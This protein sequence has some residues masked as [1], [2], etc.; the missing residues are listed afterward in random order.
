MV[1]LAVAVPVVF[2]IHPI[3]IDDVF[4]HLA[5]G[6]WMFEHHQ[7]PQ[8]DP[9]SWSR[10]GAPWVNF[11]WLFQLVVYVLYQGGGINGLI[12]WFAALS[13]LIF[14]LMA[15]LGKTLGLTT[16]TTALLVLVAAVLA[17]G[18]LAYFRP[19][20]FTMLFGVMSLL[21]L[22]RACAGR[23]V[24]MLWLFPVLLWGWS[25]M[26]GGFG[27]GLL[28]LAI[29]AV[30]AL[31]QRRW[32]GSGAPGLV[33]NRSEWKQV[34]FVATA[35]FL[36]CV[37]N[38]YGLGLIENVIWQIQ[39]SVS[40][41]LIIEWQ[42]IAGSSFGVDRALFWIFKLA[43]GWGAIGFL[44]N[45]RRTNLAR[46]MVWLVLTV[47]AWRSRRFVSLFGL[48]ALP[49]AATQ[50]QEVWTRWRERWHLPWRAIPAPVGVALVGA[51]ALGIIL[52][53]MAGRPDGIIK[54]ATVGLGIDAL[55]NP[56][57]A[58]GFLNQRV[59]RE[60]R[61]FNDMNLA[62]YQ[63]WAW[64]RQRT[65]VDPRNVFFGDAFM[66]RYVEGVIDPHGWEQLMKQYNFEAVFLNSYTE[67]NAAL[68]QILAQDSQWKRV[69]LD[70]VACVFVRTPLAAGWDQGGVRDPNDWTEVREWQQK[71]ER[72]FL[73]DKQTGTSLPGWLG[74]AIRR[75]LRERLRLQWAKALYVV[76]AKKTAQ[77][78]LEEWIESGARNYEAIYL[79]AMMAIEAHDGTRAENLL[80]QL[81]QLD[82]G[83]ADGHLLAARVLAEGRQWAAALEEAGWATAASPDDVSALFLEADLSERTGDLKRAEQCLRRAVRLYALPRP[84][85]YLRLAAVQEKQGETALALQNYR[86]A[87][88][89]WGE[90]NEEYQ[91]IKQHA[92]ILESGTGTIH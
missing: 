32:G 73:L 35:A 79:L 53:P 47:L 12:L 44:F 81:F 57:A 76:D 1:S 13:G 64:P 90:P 71:R 62:A 9:F 7:I 14:W 8:T 22:E 19:E 56:V 45:W 5:S 80:G 18:R 63:M 68:I 23:G 20:F 15:G 78:E 67:S 54:G 50:W 31:A 11:E 39:P 29:Y 83:R 24:L 25:N 36:V 38:P 75:G 42:P 91:R 85:P 40:R 17:R 58:V 89:L 52:A 65:F 61:L 88:E 2:T 21:L 46:L 34:G 84:D 74:E 60:L 27:L 37:V 3:L 77:A 86:R 10:E 6:R 70:E 87:L 28:F 59:G 49:L 41:A 30:G 48:L 51:L 72:E 82:P 92:E 33:K 16:M 43:V 69:Y 55:C 4:S 26:H 66:R